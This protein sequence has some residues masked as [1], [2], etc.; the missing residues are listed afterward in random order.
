MAK[1]ERTFIN[2]L[3]KKD[4]VKNDLIEYVSESVR[5]EKDND[6]VAMDELD[7]LGYYLENGSLT[8]TE[9]IEGPTNPNILG[10]SENI[11]TWY[12]YQRG[13]VDFAEKTRKK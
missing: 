13:E 5:L 1:L 7:Y 9:D 6:I 2:L 3:E 10:Y 11:D 8:K 12:S 4:Y